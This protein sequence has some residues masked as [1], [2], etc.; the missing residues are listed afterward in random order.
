M[1]DLTTSKLLILGIVALL[2]V[3]PKELPV[4]LRTIGKYAG[5]IRRHAAEFRVQFDDA[6]RDQELASLKAEMDAVKRDIQ[7]TVTD[8]TSTVRSASRGLEADVTAATGEIDATMQPGVRRW[9]ETAV[10]ATAEPAHASPATPEPEHQI[11][12]ANPPVAAEPAARKA[13]A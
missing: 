10:E 7:A 12:G 13:G 5:I 11:H 6:M 8:V 1:F 4:L 2:V 9:G 3:G